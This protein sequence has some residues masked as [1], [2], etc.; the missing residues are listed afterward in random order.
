MDMASIKAILSGIPAGGR[1]VQAQ[2]PVFKP[3]AQMEICLTALTR[4]SKPSSTGH[5]RLELTSSQL[6]PIF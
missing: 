5:R 2:K 1:K 3:D 6:P 4:L